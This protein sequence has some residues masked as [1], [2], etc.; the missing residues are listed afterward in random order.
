MDILQ[1][2]IPFVLFFTFLYCGNNSVVICKSKNYKNPEQKE[3]LKK[4][5]Y[6]HVVHKICAKEQ[7]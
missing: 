7:S 5:I 4:S 2:H 1:R 3:L 6:F